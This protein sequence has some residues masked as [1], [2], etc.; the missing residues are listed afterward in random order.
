MKSDSL[1]GI[2]LYA[3]TPST[4]I[5][6]GI[7]ASLQFELWFEGK[8]SPQ[9]SVNDVRIRLPHTTLTPIVATDRD[10]L[11]PNQTYCV[12]QFPIQHSTINSFSLQVQP[13]KFG[14]NVPPLTIQ[15]KVATRYKGYSD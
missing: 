2:P 3:P 10:E 15:R 12:Y 5:K 11:Y 9:C 8:P 6:T 7:T 1:L 13:A 14:C 4:H